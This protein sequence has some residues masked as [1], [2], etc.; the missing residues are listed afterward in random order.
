MTGNHPPAPPAAAATR[1]RVLPGSTLSLPTPPP[2]PSHP[3]PQP[4]H[5]YKIAVIGDALSGKSSLVDK[6]LIRKSAAAARRTTTST[7]GSN[8]AGTDNDNNSLNGGGG[9]HWC[10]AS[11]TS[12][13]T[14]GTVQ[15]TTTTSTNFT[16]SASSSLA[17]YSKKDIAL[18]KSSSS[19]SSSSSRRYE[20]TC[21]RAQ[22]WDVNVP[23]SAIENIDSN[24]SW[25][26]ETNV[27]NNNN[28]TSS[29]ASSMQQQQYNPTENSISPL[30]LPLLNRING[31][32]L[33]CPCPSPP[34]FSSSSNIPTTHHQETSNTT[35][36]CSKSTNSIFNGGNVHNH[37][38]NSSGTW[39]ELELL[40][41]QIAKWMNFIHGHV[42]GENGTRGDVSN[43]NNNY[44]HNNN[45]N[46]N[47]NHPYKIFLMLTFADL[48]IT[49]Y[50][51]N[52]W[53][54]LSLKL[55]HICG[56]FGIC[57]WRMG[58]CVDNR[59]D[60][61]GLGDATLMDNLNEP[62]DQQQW[63]RQRRQYGLLEQMARQQ[64]QMMEEMEDSVEGL[65]IDMIL[66]HLDG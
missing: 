15:S 29:V 47:N 56:K 38:G 63:Q 11:A 22:V 65:F 6:F 58:T 40:E 50:S 66:L 18:T 45:N 16:S 5:L 19:I 41:V 27:S 9:I 32:I 10:N 25:K 23:Q 4:V 7:S 51:P 36:D 13:G 49:H 57:S 55:E 37:N 52:E 35:D 54:Q 46:N 28:S 33:T 44:N 59:S 39:K 8:Y 20:T 61:G 21:V 31:I 2:P 26:N 53:M 64:Q 12:Q 62:Q 42:G 24:Y 14:F 34:S 17:T 1:I 60:G 3:P 43:N 30:L 48:A